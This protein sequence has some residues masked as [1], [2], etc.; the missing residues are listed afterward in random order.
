MAQL[1]W[2]LSLMQP[3]RSGLAVLATLALLEIALS[4]TAP[5]PLKI[6][7]DNVL[8]GHPLPAPIAGVV[9]S[10]IGSSAF[11]LLVVVVVTGLLLQVASEI[12]SMIQTHISV[13]FFV[14]DRV[15]KVKKAVDLGFLDF[16]TLESRRHFCEE[17]VRLNAA[18]APGVYLGVVPIHRRDDGSIRV[19]T[20]D[21]ED[22]GEIVEYAVEMVRLPEDRMLSAL[23]ERDEVPEH[24]A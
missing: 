5:W 13:L 11:A 10:V 22:P 20:P 12:V 14:A 7:I 4:M 16:T 9:D 21:S 18:L 8:A 15:Y 3:Y 6:V 23:L 19:G 2:T 1:R 24:F 17:E